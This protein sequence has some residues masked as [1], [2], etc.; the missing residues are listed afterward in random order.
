[1]I[2]E[3]LKEVR[4]QIARSA[5]KSGR[6]KEDVTL[7]AVTKTHGP[8]VINKAIDAGVTDIGENKV[9]EILEKYDYVKPVK[10]HLIGHLQSN[11][12]KYIIDKVSMIHSVD[13]VKL[14]SEIERQAEKQGVESIDC[15]I[16]I[17]ISGEESKSGIQPEELPGMLEYCQNLSHVKIKG[18]MTIAPFTETAESNREY[19]RQL[20][21]LAVDITNKNIDNVDME[22]LSMGMSGD[23]QVAIEE[24]ATMVRVGT[25]IFGER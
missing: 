1:M 15:L 24:G 7:I 22:V 21:E 3:R 17:N 12:V 16:Q 10:W 20:R 11:K 14:L 8:D 5:E 19:F 4:E 13:S 6:T 9:Q 23:F 2:G 18:L 25:S